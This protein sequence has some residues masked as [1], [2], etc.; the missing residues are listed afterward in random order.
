VYN[1]GLTALVHEF[2]LNPRKTKLDIQGLAIVNGAQ[3]TGALGSLDEPPDSSVEVP[4]RFVKCN[5]SDTILNIIRFNNSQ[6]KLEAADFRSND[7][8]QHRL[9][10]EFEEIPDALYLGGRR[11]G[12]ED[13][14]KRSP[15][16][17]PTDTCAQAVA[18][19]HLNP[20]VAYN[21]K[22]QIWNSD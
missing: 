8:I 15:N 21:E 6:N 19:Y 2:K 20:I 7:P 18:A 16:L 12:G 17:L 22:S 1:N 10:K 14:I 11:G 4:A 9:R 5:D 13:V 3:T